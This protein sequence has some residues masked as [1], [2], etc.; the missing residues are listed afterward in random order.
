MLKVLL[1]MCVA[2]VLFICGILEVRKERQRRAKFVEHLKKARELMDE[3]ARE[4]PN[5]NSRPI[6]E[7]LSNAL[8]NAEGSANKEAVLLI[9]LNI[10]ALDVKVMKSKMAGEIERRCKGL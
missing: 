2:L 1:F 9:L 3:Y 8:D 10:A 6:L 7:C 4:L 5:G